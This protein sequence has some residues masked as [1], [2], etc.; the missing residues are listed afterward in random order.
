ME[1]GGQRHA[2]AA[3]PPRKTRHPL[4]RR[5]GGP[6]GP[7]WTGVENLAPVGFDARTVQPVVQSL[8]RLNYPG[9]QNGRVSCYYHRCTD[10]D[11][12][13]NK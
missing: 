11:G 2:P 1:V 13:E 7:I 10:T 4:C 8:Y 12:K 6:Q 5:L 9:P 3:L